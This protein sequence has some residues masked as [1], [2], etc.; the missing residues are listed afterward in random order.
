GSP[1][2][3]NFRRSTRCTMGPMATWPC[4]FSGERV[5][6]TASAC[7]ACARRASS[8]SRPAAVRAARS[9]A[10]LARNAKRDG[11]LGGWVRHLGNSSVCLNVLRTCRGDVSLFCTSPS[12]LKQIEDVRGDLGWVAVPLFFPVTVDLPI[13]ACQR[14][15]VV[16][17]PE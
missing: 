17:A 14:M 2:G 9:D 15:P 8:G 4:D 7:G 13:E 6:V 12:F 5:A 16:P 11:D 10:T 3:L 1:P